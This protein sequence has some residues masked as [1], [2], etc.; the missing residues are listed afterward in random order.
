MPSLLSDQHRF[1]IGF[2]CSCSLCPT[3]F[4]GL[5]FLLLPCYIQHESITTDGHVLVDLLESMSCILFRLNVDQALAGLQQVQ[6]R[7]PEVNL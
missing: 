7:L 2:C 5:H 1:T 6:S 4:A 3:A